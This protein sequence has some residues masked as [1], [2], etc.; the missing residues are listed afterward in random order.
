MELA[1]HDGSELVAPA[2]AG[3]NAVVGVAAPTTS[4]CSA[5]LAESVAGAEPPP[6]VFSFLTGPGAEVGDEIAAD[7]A[8]DG[9]GF[10]G[11]VATGMHVARRAAGKALVLE[12]GGNGPLVVLD[13]ADLDGAADAALEAAFLCAGQSCTA[14]GRFLVH[15]PVREA[16][17]DRVLAGTKAVR[18]GDPLDRVTTMGPLNNKPAAAR[19]TSRPRRRSCRRRPDPRGRRRAA[20]LP[21]RVVLCADGARQRRP[22]QHDRNGGD[23]RPGRFPSWRSARTTRRSG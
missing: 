8:V 11:S 7:P 4:A 12:L 13:D 10:I 1:V 19:R 18:L 14:G 21:D 5:L 3:G 20:R 22:R 23:V 15:A 6:G 9:V 2:L 16:F 17:T